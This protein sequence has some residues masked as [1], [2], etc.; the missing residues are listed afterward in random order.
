MFILKQG[1]LVGHFA[2]RIVCTFLTAKGII[3]LQHQCAKVG[4]FD[5]DIRM[6]MSE[7]EPAAAYVLA[8]A[9]K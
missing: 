3:I 1:P 9:T 6:Q 8:R 5:L 7:I 4:Q 2:H